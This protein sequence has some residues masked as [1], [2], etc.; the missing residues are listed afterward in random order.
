MDSEA[1]WAKRAEERE[2]AWQKKS[3]ETLEKELAAYYE[4][5]LD[6]I[7]RN[8]DALYGR[9]AKD[10]ALP[11]EEA[12]KLLTGKEY[13]TWRM[14]LEEYV[15]QIDSTGNRM[16]ERELNTLAMRSRISRLD[17]LY[18]ETLIELDG[19]GRK[20]RDRMDGFLGD[21]YKDNYYRG[22]YEIGHVGKALPAISQVDPKSLEAVLRTPW[23]GKNYSTRIWKNQKQLAQV[24][25]D[26]V[27]ASVHWGDDVRKISRRVADTMGV[28][29][30]NAQ[31]LVRTELNYVHNQAA[32][33][34]IRDAEMEHFRFVATL[35]SRTSEMCREHDGK[36]YSID[37]AD[38]GENV[39]P[40][41]PRCRSII[42]GS[43]G[44]SELKGKTRIAKGDDGK[45]I[46]VPAEMN[47]E[48]FQAVYVEKTQTVEEWNKAHAP[49]KEEPL[50]AELAKANAEGVFNRKEYINAR[51]QYDAAEESISGLKETLK[52]AEAEVL[53]HPSQEV[54]EKAQQA[55]KV[56]KEAQ[57]RQKQLEAIVTGAQ[58]IRRKQIETD[59]VTKG[60][61]DK[62]VLSKHMEVASMETIQ[63]TLDRLVN[64][65]GLPKIHAIIYDPRKLVLDSGPGAAMQYS[66]ADSTM[67]L[68][69]KLNSVA[70]YKRF[71][72]DFEVK[73]KA[74]RAARVKV[75]TRNLAEAEKKLAAAK[76]PYE[77]LSAKALVNAAKYELEAERYIVA[78]SIEDTL[79]HEYGHFLHLRI[80]QKN[81]WK[82]FG[83][84]EMKAV[85]QGKVYNWNNSLEGKVLAGKVSYYAGENPHECFAEAFNAYIKGEKLPDPLQKMVKEAIEKELADEWKLME[86][87][88]R[89][90]TDN[91]IAALAKAN[92]LPY[93]IGKKGAKRFYADNGKPI[94]P[95]NSGVVGNPKI[96]TLKSGTE[97]YTRY[98]QPTGKY[99]SKGDVPFEL[100]AMPFSEDWYEDQKHYYLVLEDITDVEMGEVAPW[101]G[102]PGGSIQYK[103]PKSIAD[104]EGKIKEL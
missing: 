9:F 46:H 41:H 29:I 100:R 26:E 20:V 36:I 3:R 2:A 28:G 14:S 90:P 88:L 44:G 37:E 56:L 24:I 72:A 48:D 39:P 61:A 33:D 104:L 31:R 101:F 40:L 23:S 55:S 8:I 52:A 50:F 10:N 65:M 42:V 13:R 43:L 95:P 103:L 93:T 78:N 1:Y 38:T 53:T 87:N 89:P 45:Y 59:M 98:G 75:Y 91:F 69:H 68:G 30:S 97:I 85:K 21:A 35:D 94:Y 62:V 34:S 92:N 5:S 57:A 63:K 102:Q 32:L 6:H 96:I 79:I 84:K 82:M 17:K 12:R 74:A 58:D 49:K 71:V 15:A 67:Y 99:I 7:Q 70:G 22:L 83:S 4:A 16:L 66:V 25:Q 80:E 27:V 11:M 18:S 19:L 73:F 47:Y 81:S 77:K 60:I 86:V 54:W 51:A 64:E 76:T